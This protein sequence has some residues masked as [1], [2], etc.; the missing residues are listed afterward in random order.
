MMHDRRLGQKARIAG[1][2]SAFAFRRF[3]LIFERRYS[4]NQ[5]RVPTGQPGAGQWMEGSGDRDQT[6]AAPIVLAGG[7]N[8][9]DENR[10]VQEFMSANCDGSIR[11][12]MPEQMLDLTIGEVQA[13]AKT[14]DSAARTCLKLLGRDEYKK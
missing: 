9:G 1:E 13:L 5:P 11:S 3:V 6:P 2:R 14:G 4:E 7:F 10:T 8:Q 12:R